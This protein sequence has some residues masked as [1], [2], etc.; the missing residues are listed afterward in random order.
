MRTLKSPEPAPHQTACRICRSHPSVGFRA[1]T[2]YLRTTSSRV[3]ISF[4]DLVM[5]GMVHRSPILGPNKPIMR[6]PDR[7]EGAAIFSLAPLGSRDRASTDHFGGTLYAGLFREKQSHFERSTGLSPILTLKQHPR[8][9]DVSGG[10]PMPLTFTLSSITQ[11]NLQFESL[12]PSLFTQTNT[13]C[14]VQHGLCQSWLI[15]SGFTKE[16]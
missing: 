3:K 10:A 16:A 7:D 6:N 4:S 15:S 13:A 2:F 8:T 14:R 12:S 11:R 9:T 5:G 1:D